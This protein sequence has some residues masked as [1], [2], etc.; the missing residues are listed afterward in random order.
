MISSTGM[1]PWVPT[2]APTVQILIFSQMT[3][4]LDILEDYLAWKG[5]SFRRIDGSMSSDLRK[6][7]IDDFQTDSSIDI[8]LLSTR[9][10]GLGVNLI[11]ADTC[12][13][14]D[15]D[16]YVFSFPLSFSTHLFLLSYLSPFITSAP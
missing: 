16:W 11:A 3:R 6:N 15:S 9:A 10:G 2:V 13:I 5:L 1:L 8:F 14:F 12:I 7:A 4:M